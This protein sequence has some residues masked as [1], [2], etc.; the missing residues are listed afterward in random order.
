MSFGQYII[1]SKH[2]F[3]EKQTYY[4]LSNDKFSIEK[5]PVTSKDFDIGELQLIETRGYL[6]I[7]L[8]ERLDYPIENSAACISLIDILVQM[9]FYNNGTDRKYE[10]TNLPDRPDNFL[11]NLSTVYIYSENNFKDIYFTLKFTDDTETVLFYNHNMSNLKL[12]S[13]EEIETMESDHIILTVFGVPDSFGIKNSDNKYDIFKKANKFIDENKTYKRFKYEYDDEDRNKVIELMFF[14]KYI[15]YYNTY[16]NK[17]PILE[18]INIPS[19]S[20]QKIFTIPKDIDVKLFGTS[21]KLKEKLYQETGNDIIYG[22]YIDS[23]NLQISIQRNPKS[24]EKFFV[25]LPEDRGTVFDL[26]EGYRVEGFFTGELSGEI[27]ITGASK[28]NMHTRFSFTLTNKSIKLTGQKIYPEYGDNKYSNIFYWSKINNNSDSVNSLTNSY[29][30][31]EQ[32]NKTN[33]EI[34]NL[35]KFTEN[36]RTILS[37]PNLCEEK[38]EKVSKDDMKTFFKTEQKPN[39]Y[40]ISSVS[41]DNSSIFVNGVYKY[42]AVTDTYYNKTEYDYALYRPIIHTIISTSL[43]VID[44]DNDSYEIVLNGIFYDPDGVQLVYLTFII[45]NNMITDVSWKKEWQKKNDELLDLEDAE[46]PIQFSDLKDVCTLFIYGL[47]EVYEH[48]GN[49]YL[50]DSKTFVEEQRIITSEERTS[51]NIKWL[52]THQAGYIEIRFVNKQRKQVAEVLIVTYQYIVNL[53]VNED[54]LYEFILITKTDQL[55]GKIYFELNNKVV[56]NKKVCYTNTRHKIFNDIGINIKTPVGTY[57][58]TTQSIIYNNGGSNYICSDDTEWEITDDLISVLPNKLRFFLKL[59]SCTLRNTYIDD[60]KLLKEFVADK[61]INI[62][63][64]MENNC[65]YFNSNGFCSQQCSMFMSDFCNAEQ[66]VYSEYIDNET[67]TKVCRCFDTKALQKYMISEYLSDGDTIGEVQPII[68]VLKYARNMFCFEKECMSSRIKDSI[69]DNCTENANDII[70]NS[71]DNQSTVGTLTMSQAIT[72][73]SFYTNGGGVVDDDGG[74]GNS[75]PG[76][77]TITVENNKT[78]TYIMVVSGVLLS[79]FLVVFTYLLINKKKN[80][81]PKTQL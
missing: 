69:L 29:Y 14:F 41:H 53:Q 43:K 31:I 57:N 36:T 5:K 1:G 8:V 2:N 27:E 42:D 28:Y 63:S 19:I 80:N 21:W 67:K 25:Y 76:D 37:I 56:R 77:N 68:T 39:F 49:V 3:L 73:C 60:N 13:G 81:L 48:N 35:L 65:S 72:N 16:N 40:F 55:D 44:N 7:F 46:I 51:F 17:T 52:D 20:N 32:T 4:M 9:E 30:K 11:P 34:I 45:K 59:L 10:V 6:T 54:H 26:I 18:F 71:C 50:L 23:E 38:T 61:T 24:I 64:N 70:F 75:V 12:F 74:G 22:E 62:Q 33:I 15:D 58:N 66:D 79:F 47:N 78:P